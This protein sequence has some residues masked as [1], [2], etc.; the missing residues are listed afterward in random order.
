M[1]KL[2]IALSMVM[3]STSA[4]SDIRFL[5]NKRVFTELLINEALTQLIQG[6]GVLKSPSVSLERII[7]PSFVLNPDKECWM[8]PQYHSDGGVTPR[9]V[10]H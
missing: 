10:C 8:I 1:K 2:L 3:I 4:S 9:L 6:K 5:E 7:T